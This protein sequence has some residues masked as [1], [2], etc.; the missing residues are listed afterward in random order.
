MTIELAEGTVHLEPFWAQIVAPLVRQCEERYSHYA[1]ADD[2]GQE[3]A[4]WWYSPNAQK[5][6]REYL[7]EEGFTRLRRS[8]WRAMAR[9]AEKEK[10]HKVGYE[11]EDQVLYTPAQV[12][13]VLPVALDPEG[14]PD[15]GGVADIT[16]IRA[17]TNLAEG[18]GVLASLIDVRRGLTTL[19]PADRVLLYVANEELHDWDSVADRM[20]IGA[21]TPLLADSFRR[22]HDR[23]IERIARSLNGEAE[24]A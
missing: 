18:G 15:G 21:E 14:L 10:G 4:V 5:H 20:N 22:K 23:V 13:A 16:G 17:H 12:A 9:Y 11:P 19:V 6:L 3:C 8:L 24:A 1:E 2:L 7:Q